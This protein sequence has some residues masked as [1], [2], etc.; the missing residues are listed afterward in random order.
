MSATAHAIE[1]APT[2]DLTALRRMSFKELDALY[3]AAK[4]PSALSDLDGD[5]VGA[6]LAWR[7]PTCGPLAW[8]LRTFGASTA[9]PWEGNSFQSRSHDLGAGIHRVKFSGKRRWFPLKTRFEDSLLHGNPTF[10]L[11]CSS[12]GNPPFIR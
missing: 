2:L 10:L 4:R 7:S 1:E 3:R 6:M 12:T 5:A 8:C 11:D 9:F